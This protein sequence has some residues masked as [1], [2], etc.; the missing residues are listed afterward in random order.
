MTAK[1]AV[2]FAVIG[3]LSPI[4]LV[5]LYFATLGLRDDYAKQRLSALVEAELPPDATRTQM[6]GFLEKN[7]KEWFDDSEAFRYYGNVSNPIIDSALDRS[8]SIFLYY[9]PDNQE[10]T[11]YEVRISY[12]FV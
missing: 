4:A 3:I 8:I 11:D 10:M 7:T 6:E 5:F 1:S 2:K 9:D 12:T